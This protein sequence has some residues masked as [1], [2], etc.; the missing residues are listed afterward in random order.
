[1][2]EY[3]KGL[4]DKVKRTLPIHKVILGNWDEVDPGD[5]MS[6]TFSNNLQ[7]S[8]HTDKQLYQLSAAGAIERNRSSGYKIWSTG[9]EEIYANSHV[10]RRLRQN[11]GTIVSTNGSLVKDLG[12]GA[13][14]GKSKPTGTELVD[15]IVHYA[16]KDESLKNCLSLKRLIRDK[17][18]PEL[19]EIVSITSQLYKCR[20]VCNL[21]NEPVEREFGNL[22]AEVLKT[23]LQLDKEDF[24]LTN[25]P[26]VDATLAADI[27]EKHSR[28]PS[29]LND[30]KIREVINI[31]RSCKRY[32]N[33]DL[34]NLS[35]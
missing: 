9:Y 7:A 25:N 32:L 18:Q 12:L 28:D 19:R 29:I 21:L 6:H 35:Q 24:S 20:D 34:S 26:F 13:I 15:A 8:L 10:I 27:Y 1:M 14:L 23:I 3:M 4:I 31:R 17:C 2:V 22:V 5:S 30:R 33:I 16:L 11:R